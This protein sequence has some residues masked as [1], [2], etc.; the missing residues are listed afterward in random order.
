MN[1]LSCTGPG[2]DH[3]VAATRFAHA[4]TVGPEHCEWS[5][6]AQLS[7][8]PGKGGT[9]FGGHVVALVWI[10]R[11][12]PVRDGPPRDVSRIGAP[13][14]AAPAVARDG[15]FR[16]LD[17]VNHGPDRRCGRAKARRGYSVEV[18]STL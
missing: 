16:S 2:F 3:R 12:M 5:L 1:R 13:E 6:T 11:S 15:Q 14:G 8:V 7:T 10:G 18:M 17:I 9:T 4:D